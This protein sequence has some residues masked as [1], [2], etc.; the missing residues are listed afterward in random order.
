M[1]YDHIVYAFGRYFQAGEEVPEEEPVQET[2]PELPVEEESVEATD[3][4]RRRRG[5]RRD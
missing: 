1:K 5:R 2:I 4:K 3:D